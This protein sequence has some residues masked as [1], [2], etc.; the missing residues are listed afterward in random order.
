MIHLNWAC[1]YLERKKREKEYFTFEIRRWILTKSFMD[2]KVDK[3]SQG[4][5]ETESFLSKE[6]KKKKKNKNFDAFP[7][8]KFSTIFSL[9]HLSMKTFYKSSSKLDNISDV[10]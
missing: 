5:I 2:R 3:N 7:S 8:F 1:I 9:R 10:G 4:K 6:L